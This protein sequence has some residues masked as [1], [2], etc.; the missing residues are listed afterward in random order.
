MRPP[1]LYEAVLDE[2]ASVWRGRTE[3]KKDKIGIFMWRVKNELKKKSKSW[4]RVTRGPKDFVRV[5]TKEVP[6]E[7]P[8]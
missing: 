8:V 4:T 1:M 2:A 5:K 7:R 6:L 3:K